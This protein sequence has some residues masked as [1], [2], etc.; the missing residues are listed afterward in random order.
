[1]SSPLP[2]LDLLRVVHP[3]AVRKI[4]GVRK[5]CLSLLKALLLVPGECGV[6][7]VFPRSRG[8]ARANS[9]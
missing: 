8:A 6:G 2:R 7:G 4:Q 1:M 3:T 5:N 9:T